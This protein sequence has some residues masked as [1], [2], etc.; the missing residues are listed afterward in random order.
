MKFAHSLHWLAALACLL[1][2]PR[3][4]AADDAGFEPIFDGKTLENWD[5]NP[6]FWRVEDGTITGQT[7]KEKP[8]KGNTFIIWRGE[9]RRVRTEARLQDRRRQL[10][11]SGPRSFEVKDQKWVIGGYQGD[12][13]AGDTSRA[14]TTAKSFTASSLPAWQEDREM[15]ADHK[16]KEVG[17][18]GD[19]KQLQSKIKKEDWNEYHIITKGF[20]FHT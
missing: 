6:D 14:S 9:R 20:N 4:A 19:T 5:G 1:I 15:G 2:A 16:P 8:T 11:A 3:C 12:F 17:V 7:T 13:E 10:G 18:I